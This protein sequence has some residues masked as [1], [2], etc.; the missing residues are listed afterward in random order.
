MKSIFNEKD[1]IELVE[2]INKLTPGTSPEWGKMNSSRMLEHCTVSIKL[3]LNEIEPE[4]NEE[5]LKLG[6]LVKNRVFES[7]VFLKELPTSKEFLILEDGNFDANRKSFIEYINNFSKSNQENELHGKHP[8]F[9]ELTMKE[10]GMLIWKHT[11]HHLI[12]FSL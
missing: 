3:A 7:E 6:R 2:R 9:G 5:Y 12:Q 1:R 10:W 4:Q 11:N 8:Y